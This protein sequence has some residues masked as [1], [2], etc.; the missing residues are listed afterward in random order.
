MS[1]FRAIFCLWALVLAACGGPTAN[2]PPEDVLV[3]LADDE[4]K[5][6]DPHAVSDLASLRVAADQ[7]EGL[8]RYAAN[9]EIEP[10]LAERWSVSEDGLEWEFT[11]RP[12][13]TF[14]DGAPIAAPLFAAV[15]ERLRDPATAAPTASLFDAI[16]AVEA[17]TADRVHIAL[18]YPYPALL[19]LLA[20]PAMAALPLHRITDAGDDWTSERPLVTSG[21]YRLT[22]WTLND[23]ALLER[24]PQWHE[25]AAPIPQIEWRPVDDSLTAMRIFLAGGADIAGEFPSTRLAWLQTN[26]PDATRIAPYRGAYYFAFNTREPPFDDIR[27]RRALSL[28]VDRRWISEELLAIGT[29]PA[30]GIIPPGLSGLDR[31]RPAWVDS[32]RED[33]RDQARALLAGAGYGPDNPLT[34]DIRFNSTAEHRR[35]SVA[36]AAMWEPLGVEAQL[37]NSEATLHFAA[38]RRA[39]FTLARSGWIGDISAP[40]NFLAVHRSDAGAINYSGYANPAY[41]AALDAALAEPEP[42][43]RAQLMRDAEAILV[44]DAPILP[45]YFYVSRALVSPRVSGWVDNAA[46]VHPSRTL[47]LSTAQ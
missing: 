43:R 10:G 16:A 22:D 12:N 26:R 39:D 30:W 27:V 9:A 28:A 46:N 13:L 47:L 17:P 24:N 14:S 41:D 38:L 23:R 36:L 7:F 44:A 32:S 11:L 31:L 45:I 1:P 35:V 33:R 18:A 5:S 21:A 40:E 42:A 20:H 4:I 19:E 15:F 2:A 25:G 8:T 6:L 29:A 37:F 3:R 34:F